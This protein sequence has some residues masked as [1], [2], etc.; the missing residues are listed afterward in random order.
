[1]K[2]IRDR[3]LICMNC[4]RKSPE[5]QD[6]KV[7]FNGNICVCYECIEEAWCK[8]SKIDH[9]ERIEGWAEDAFQNQ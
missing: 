4:K 1:M 5:V 3:N 8:V 7:I 9:D 6:S 2:A